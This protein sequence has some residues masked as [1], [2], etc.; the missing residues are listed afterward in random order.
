MMY[1][2]NLISLQKFNIKIMLLCNKGLIMGTLKTS[3]IK[4]DVL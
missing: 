1:S 2:H 3:E 4:L